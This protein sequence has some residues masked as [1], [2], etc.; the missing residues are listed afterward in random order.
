MVMSE[1]RRYMDAAMDRLS[2][3]KAQQMAR[4][5]MK[6]QGRDQVQKAAKDLMKWSGKSRDRLVALVRREV[7]AQLKTMGAATRDEV[8]ALKKRIRELER[9]GAPK[10]AAAKR[11]AKKR[12]ATTK[13]SAKRRTAARPSA[14]RKA[15]G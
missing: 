9:G 11:P 2:P 3:A 13:S 8:D 4:S 15:R 12:S 10:R 6:G 5:V 1:V 7:K 14:A